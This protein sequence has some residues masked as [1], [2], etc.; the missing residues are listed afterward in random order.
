M[1]EIPEMSEIYVPEQYRANEKYKKDALELRRALEHLNS[2][3]IDML[4]DLVDNGPDCFRRHGYKNFTDATPKIIKNHEKKEAELISA[5][6][7]KYP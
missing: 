3:T 4:F 2:I 1:S 7:K 5:F 6:E